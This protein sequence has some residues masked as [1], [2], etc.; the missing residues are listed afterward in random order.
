MVKN[1]ESN[2]KTDFPSDHFPV[3]AKL[4]IKL[5]KHRG[6]PP[7]KSNEW[8]SLIKPNEEN[9]NKFN[10]DSQNHYQTWTVGHENTNKAELDQKVDAFQFAILEAAK[11]NIEKK[12]IINQPVKRS[13]ELENLFNERRN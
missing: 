1:V 8:K 11:E 12:P 13:A 10:N 6:R 4:K 7:D 2:T 3:E 5:A 9:Q